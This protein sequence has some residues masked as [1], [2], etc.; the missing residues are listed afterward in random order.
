MDTFF[1]VMGNLLTFGN[2]LVIA[3]G[4]IT[5]LIFGALPGLGGAIAIV[6]MLPITYLLTPLQSILLLL[7]TY[8]ASEYGGSISSITLGIPGTP[9]AAATVLDGYPY[10]KNHSPSK[11]LEVS[12][13]ASTIGGLVGGLALMFISVPLAHFAIKLSDPEFFLIGILGLMAVGMLSSKSKIK[14]LISVILGLMIGTVG[15]D[16]LTGAQRATFNKPVLMDGINIVPLVVGVFVIPSLLLMISD[17]PNKRYVTNRKKLKMRITLKEFRSIL[18]PTGIGTLI[19]VVVGIFPG[20]GGAA[21]NWFAYAAAKKAS[22][23]PETFGTGNIE[24][25]AAPESSNNAT[26]GSSLIP[27]LALGIPGSAGSALIMSAFIIHGIQPGPQ[28]L[29]RE[30]SLVY[31]I[32]Y[33]FILTTFVMFVFGR[34]LTPAFSRVLTIPT[35]IIV[36]AIAIIAMSGVYL[37]KHSFFDVWFAFIFGLIFFVL[38]KLNFSGPSIVV[39]YI[40][41]PIVEMSLR[42]ALLLSD[43]SFLIFIERP[44]SL[45]ILILI[46][47]IVIIGVMRNSF[48]Q[49]P[50]IQNVK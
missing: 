21:A 10:A 48:Q 38:R 39:G 3:I 4:T 26:V 5:G 2:I 43:G 13:I 17:G 35:S 42:R 30:T 20:V 6:M 24:G 23:N 11:A 36:P 50:V 27:M 40:L 14:G 18:K 22:R 29:M 45:I 1:A 7:A 41:C 44:Y 15:M 12:L 33:G 37:T 9:S 47:L 25:I 8:Q 16:L 34:L 31:G 28:V 46:I 49:K 32:F 19:G